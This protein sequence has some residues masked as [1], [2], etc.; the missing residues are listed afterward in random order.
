MESN[1]RTVAELIGDKKIGCSANF[2]DGFDITVYAARYGHVNVATELLKNGANPNLK[3]KSNLSALLIA[4][5]NN[6]TNVV[7]KLKAA[8]AIQ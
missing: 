8:G 2:K 4:Q 7:K 6:R 3:D 5:K 1:V